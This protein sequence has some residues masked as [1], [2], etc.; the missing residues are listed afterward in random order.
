MGSSSLHIGFDRKNTSEKI[1]L[2]IKTLKRHFAALGS[3]GSGKT[4]LV[5]CVIEE[6]IRAGIPLII[7][8]IQ[9]DLASLAMM[10]DKNQVEEKGTPGAYYDEIKNKAQV[11]IYTPASTKGIPISMNPLKAPPQDMDHEDLIQAIDSVAVTVA[12]ILKYNI[13]KGK[14]LE[15]KNYLY[16]LL[17]AIWLEDLNVESFSELGNYIKN[18]LDYLDETA[19]SMIDEK[20]KEELLKSVTGLTIGA[21]SLIFNMGVPL[22]IHRMMTWADPGKVPINVL[23]LNTIRD[24]DDRVSFIANVSTQIY[25]WMLKNPSE[26]VQL[27]YI[28]DELAGLVPPT[29]NPPSKKSIQLLLKQ[30]RKYGVSLLL[31]TQNISDVDYKSLGQVGTW[32]LGRLMAKQDIEKVRDI[33]QSISP[34]E[35]DIILSSISVQKA[36]QFI[37]LAPDVFKEVR[38]INARWLV[39]NHTTLDDVKVKLLMDSTGIREKFP[40]AVVKRTNRKTKKEKLNDDKD[41]EDSVN[42]DTKE[43]DDEAEEEG[44]TPLLDVSEIPQDINDAENI[45]KVLDERPIALSVQEIAEIAGESSVKIIK[46]LDKLVKNKKLDKDEINGVKVYWSIKHKMDPKNHIIG[47]LFRLH[48]E[49]H[50]G[51]AEKIMK[52]NIP[53]TLGIRALED[54]VD[55]ETELYYVPLWRI[56]VLNTKKSKNKIIRDK[57]FHYVNG[58]TGE[59]LL[60]NSKDSKIEFQTTIKNIKKVDSIPEKILE[61]EVVDGLKKSDLKPEYNREDAI[62]QITK[63]MGL[64]IDRNISPALVWLPMW[65]FV[66]VDK[67]TN[68]ERNAWIDGTFGTY[69]KDNPF[70]K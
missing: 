47:S 65:Q 63:L 57:K 21:D 35:T 39:T 45:L 26:D 2:P 30:A 38:M 51:E 68:Q 41:E 60:Y 66:L 40:D 61:P 69:L 10:G 11:A 43:S 3:S 42:L 50:Q 20:E 55:D 58:L 46:D 64:R 32:A 53:K 54:I 22:D 6:C 56:G 44:E 16:L 15:V 23:Y 8:D 70:N 28:L 62:D 13:D 18:D 7:I 25:N 29:R 19:S 17:E 24:A 31:A 9:G 52:G 4:V 12:S 67:D 5:K 33:I 37:L 49:K 1:E 59:I 14:G 48:V 36:G 27:V 34:K